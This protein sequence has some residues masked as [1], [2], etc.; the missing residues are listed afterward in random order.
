M[1]NDDTRLVLT[2]VLKKGL[3][4]WVA[5][6]LEFDL[7]AQGPTQEDALRSFERVLAGQLMLDG[8][9]M[10]RPLEGIRKASN[11]WQQLATH[12]NPAQCELGKPPLKHSNW[13]EFRTLA[14][15]A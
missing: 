11:E 10:R 3:R 5:Q 8:M 14:A 6:C 12:A 9:K 1:E 13:F 7:A 2:V 15:D 4:E